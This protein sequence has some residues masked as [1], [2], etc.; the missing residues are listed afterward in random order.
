MTSFKRKSKLL[1]SFFIALLLAACKEAVV[2]NLS[3]GDANRVVTVLARENVVAEKRVEGSNWS[4]F[5]DSNKFLRALEVLEVSRIFARSTPQES[6][7]SSFVRSKEEIQ[8]EIE[9]DIALGLEETILRL[10]GVLDA[11]VHLFVFSENRLEVKSHSSRITASVL[12]VVDSNYSVKEGEIRALVSGA[13]GIGADNVTIVTSM[14]DRP[15]VAEVSQKGEEGFDLGAWSS[16]FIALLGVAFGGLCLII[17][18][19]GSRRNGGRR[20][21]GDVLRPKS[22]ASVELGDQNQDGRAALQ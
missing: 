6:R 10:P 16:R 5:V 19:L 8:R 17:G 18:Y 13:S 1:L 3:E 7:S 14:S 11:R 2:H 4:V 21:S 9:R 12:L 15:K 20:S 22:T